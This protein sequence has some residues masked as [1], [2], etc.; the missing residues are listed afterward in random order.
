LI[1]FIHEM[2]LQ[3]NRDNILWPLTFLSFL[4]S[5]KCH[6]WGALCEKFGKMHMW[7]P[8]SSSRNK[9]PFRHWV[10]GRLHVYKSAYELRTIW[11]KSDGHPISCTIRKL[12]VYTFDT[13]SRSN[14]YTIWCPRKAIFLFRGILNS[15]EYKIGADSYRM[16]NRMVSKSYAD[17]CA[18]SYV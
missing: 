16:G 3:W 8:C 15:V 10:R 9:I 11:Y 5:S 2:C 18:D 13:I 17:S 1:A 4:S 14:P 6:L 7:R 12:S